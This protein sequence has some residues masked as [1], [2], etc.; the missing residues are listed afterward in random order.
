[1]RAVKLR[2]FNLEDHDRLPYVAIQKASKPYGFTDATGQTSGKQ[3]Q[4]FLDTILP[5]SNTAAF[6]VIRNDSI[7]YERYFNG[8]TQQSLLPS[9]SVVKSFIGTLIAIAVDEGHIPSTQIPITHYL[10]ELLQRDKAFA[11]ITIQHL[12]DMRSGI[13][14]NEE[15][16]NLKDD[17]IKLG[18]RPNV[19]KHAL[20]IRIEKEPGQDFQYRSINT[21]LLGFILE[22]ATGK[23][24]SDLLQ[25]KIWEPLGAEYHATW[26]VDSWKRKQ[27]ISFAGLNAAARDFAKLG[28]LYLHQGNWNGRKILKQHWVTTVAHADIMN[29]F[30][31]YKN[32]WWSRYLYH[33]FPD[34]LDAIAYSKQTMRSGIVRK[35]RSG[36]RVGYR[37]GA[38]SAHGVFNQIIYI[39]PLNNVIIVRFGK[40]WRH[41]SINAN[42]FV[43]QLGASL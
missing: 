34:S 19:L 22:R 18:F 43:Y 23:K 14:F 33:Y 37:N 12:M 40:F 29:T 27:E 13:W 7:L 38:F 15:K 1:M 16:Y 2:K 26:N 5:F 39:N 41:P 28:R 32:Q 31:G 35:S 36:F 42:Q 30:S 21:Q 17:A 3:L 20:R 8:F 4:S 6:I 24:V 9:F 11:R 25:E 10:P